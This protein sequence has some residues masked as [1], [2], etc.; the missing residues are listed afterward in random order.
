MSGVDSRSG[1]TEPASHALDRLHATVAARRGADPE[2]SYTARLLARGAPKIAQKLGEEAV[3][4]VIEAVRLDDARRAG[5]AD[6]D[7]AAAR[8][9]LVE[10]SADLLYHLTVLWAALDVDPARV[11]TALDAR[12]GRGGLD[13]KKA[14]RGG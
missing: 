3:E 11:W 2:A 8:Q 9:A 5:A 10:E 7:E 4:A 13:E 14:R 12:R 6:G 1:T